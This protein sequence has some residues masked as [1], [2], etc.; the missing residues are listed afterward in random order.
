MERRIH[1]QIYNV[2]GQLA[3]TSDN[4]NAML[5][6]RSPKL[7]YDYRNDAIY[8]K[9]LRDHFANVGWKVPVILKA[10]VDAEKLYFDEICQIKMSQWTKGRVALIGDAAHCAG[11]PTGMGTSLAMR[12][13]TLLADEL[14]KA[15]GAHESAFAN[16]NRIFHPVVE[17]IQDTIEQGLDF[18][19]PATSEAI[20]LRNKL[21]R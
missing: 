20:D 17:P 21:I 10:M 13:A 9:I 12:G 18:L 11:F 15:A 1:G 3:A 6:F 16:Y 14:L 19:V 5:L 7:V 4:G 2:P 8:K